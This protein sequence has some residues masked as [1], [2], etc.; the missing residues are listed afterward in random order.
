VL[1][2]LWCLALGRPASAADADQLAEDEQRLKAVKLGTDGKS[3]L[4]FLRTRTRPDMDQDKIG[5]LIKDLG[6]DSSKVAD[7]AVR[8]VIALGQVAVPWLRRA[9]KDPDDELATKRARFCLESLEGYEGASIP[10]AAAHLLALRKTPGAV[11]VM[12][13]YLPF[14]DDDT[15]VDELR[16]A[17]AALAVQDGQPDKALVEALRDK[18]PV[19]RA[20]AAEALCQAGARDELPAIRYL[21][22]DPKPTVQLRVAIA[23]AGAKEEEAVKVLIESLGK[24]PED[25][26]HLAEE[27]LVNLAGTTAPSV[28]LGKDVATRKRARDTW[29][30]WYQSFKNK[31]LLKYFKDRTLDDANTATFQALIKQLGSDSYTVRKRATDKL[32]AYRTAAL[33]LLKKALSD[34][35]AEISRRARICLRLINAAPQAGLSAAHARILAYRKPAGAVPILLAYLPFAD[36]DSVAEDVRNTLAVIAIRNGKADKDLLVALRDKFPARRAAAAEALIQA[37][38]T[39]QKKALTRLLKDPETP[40]R[41]RVALALVNA[42]DKEAVPTLIDLLAELPPEEG[43][44]AEEVLRQIAGEKGPA[45]VLTE[46]KAVRKKARDAWAAW[47]KAN[48]AKV[49]LARTN[50]VARLLGYTIIAQYD[51]R[52]QSDIYE[53]DKKGK[54]RWRISNL[55]YAFNFQ[56][57]RGKR[58]LIPEYQ[59][60]RVTERDFKGKV[61]WEYK[62]YSPI[63]CQRLRNG[64]TFIASRN[65]VVE[66]DRNKKQVYKISRPN[67]DVM[68]AHKL[69]NGHIYL[70]TNSGSLIHMDAKRKEIKSFNVGSV[71]YYG[72]MDVLRNGHVLIPE[73]NSSQVREYD[74][75]GK[76][77]WKAACMQWPNSAVR[78]PNGHTLVASQSVQ[79]VWE[80][81]RNGKKVWEY[82]PSGQPWCV[83]RR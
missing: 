45:V 78:L 72:S 7:K 26:A 64:N 63:S 1:V 69:R 73:Y 31:A 10:I 20:V 11:P 6:S 74:Q 25:R 13:A 8:K 83:K 76:V 46:D 48:G 49:D 18:V 65:G 51:N 81:D 30:T 16:D 59:G 36:D 41:M 3:L 28:A 44:K 66:I 23:L 43:W 79:Q 14:A 60:G 54:V 17:L 22:K 75:N 62:V 71:S 68:A 15:V 47:W 52:G 67:Y 61:H 58:L 57:L 80:L 50:G 2:A 39:G 33:P 12:L 37:G 19:R 82:K 29:N 5:E 32:I 40:V 55:S 38:V 21:L 27:V 56:I 70:L 9:L 53:V 42:K 24:L 4:E 35:D 34:K 77:V